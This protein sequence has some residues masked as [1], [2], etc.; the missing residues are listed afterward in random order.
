[1]ITIGS[2]RA[3]DL[4]SSLAISIPRTE[5]AVIRHFQTRMP[6]GGSGGGG[7]LNTVHVADAIARQGEGRAA[8]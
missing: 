4:W 3:P 7:S 2:S 8:R 5:A 6:G 1:M